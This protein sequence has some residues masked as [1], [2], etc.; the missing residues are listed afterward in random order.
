MDFQRKWRVGHVGRDVMYYEEL[1]DGKWERLSL[2]GELQTGR[3]HH[4][5]FFDSKEDWARYPD[6]AKDRREEI[7]QRVMNDFR[8]PD[9]EYYFRG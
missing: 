6:W 8:E 2:D 4:M 9:Y 5:I 1:V 3:A 7:I